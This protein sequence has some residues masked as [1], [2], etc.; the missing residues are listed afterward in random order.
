M[1]LYRIQLLITTDNIILILANT[2]Q[3]VFSQV[4]DS[5]PRRTYGVT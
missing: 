5:R 2:V 4:A 1:L 3:F